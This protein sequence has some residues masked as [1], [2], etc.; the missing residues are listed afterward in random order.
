MGN[1]NRLRIGILFNVSRNW[2]GGVYYIVNLVN[3][4]NHLDEDDKPEL[5]LFHSEELKDFIPQIRYTKLNVVPWDFPSPLQGYAMSW[6]RQKNWFSN[7]LALQ[8]RLDGIY[9][10][11]NQPIHFSRAYSR[12]LR[13]VS[14][15]ADLQHK[16]FPE[17]FSKKQLMMREFRLRMMLRNTEHLVVSSIA[18]END[19]RKFYKLRS[20]LKVHVLNF[21]SMIDNYTPIEEEGL[22]EKYRLP[23]KYFIV[24]NQFHRHK[25]HAVLLKALAILKDRNRPV[26]IAMTGKM[27]ESD[28]SVYIRDLHELMKENGLQDQVTFLGVIPRNDQLNLMKH[29]QAVVQPSLF[30]GWSTVIEDATAMEVPVIASNL[31]VNIEQL[32]DAGLFFDPNEEKELA[33]LLMNY[34]R[35]EN[36]NFQTDYEVRIKNFATTFVEIFQGVR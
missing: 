15:F 4:L 20:D 26:H 16:Y 11:W 28:T 35:Q 23:E 36:D 19:F 30:E 18:A 32:G 14:W 34:K 10:E 24:S 22:R 17:F 7:D 29:S 12:P 21:V 9:P 5:F 2:L 8:Y 1:E 3:A 6:I 31:D 33:E 25:N 27:P 13:S